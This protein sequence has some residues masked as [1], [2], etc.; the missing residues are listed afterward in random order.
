MI[1]YRGVERVHQ[2]NLDMLAANEGRWQGMTGAGDPE[3][4]MM[5]AIVVERFGGPEQLALQRVAQTV[6]CRGQVLVEIAAAGVNPVERGRRG[7][8]IMGAA[9]RS[10]HPWQRWVGRDRRAGA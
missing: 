9:R 6:P 2:E 3:P 10:L 1:G 7:R 4:A 5:D 8:R